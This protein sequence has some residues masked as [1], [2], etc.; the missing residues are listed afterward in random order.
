MQVD[1]AGL[2]ISLVRHSA[3][4]I[5]SMQVDETGV[6]VSLVRR[7]DRLFGAAQ[8]NQR[9]GMQVDQTGLHHLF[10]SP[11]THRCGS[12]ARSQAPE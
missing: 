12:T 8:R 9:D 1:Q 3:T 7:S 10:R 4:K 6:I 11:R 2:N 5:D